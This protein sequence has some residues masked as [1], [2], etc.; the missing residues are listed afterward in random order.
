MA[1]LKTSKLE[2]NAMPV[3]INTY[4]AYLMPP[5]LAPF[6]LASVIAS[7][8]PASVPTIENLQASRELYV[9]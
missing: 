7:Y 6:L 4:L 8:L 3:F 9:H 1:Q 5:N 2:A